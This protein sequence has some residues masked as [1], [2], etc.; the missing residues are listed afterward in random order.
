MMH[1]I[2]ERIKRGAQAVTPTATVTT[3]VQLLAADSSVVMHR[4]G[5]TFRVEAAATPAGLMPDVA[6]PLN[7]QVG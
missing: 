3:V 4:K 1:S 5:S 6:Y 7:A 2:D